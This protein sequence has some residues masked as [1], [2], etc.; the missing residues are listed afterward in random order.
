MI[1]L[2]SFKTKTKQKKP[3]K[4]PQTTLP[5]QKNPKQ[6]PPQKN[7]T[8]NPKQNPTKQTNHNTQKS[9]VFHGACTA[10]IILPSDQMDSET[11][12]GCRVPS[13]LMSQQLWPAAP[14][15]PLAQPKNLTKTFNVTS[16]VLVEGES[17]LRNKP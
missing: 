12:N 7:L 2:S 17:Q 4:K 16:A 6:P 8:P 3:T 15:T 5:P 13:W 1:V 11:P 14:I 9:N 10:L